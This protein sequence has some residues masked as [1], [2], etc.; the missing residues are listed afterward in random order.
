MCGIIHEDQ[1]VDY[2]ISP[3]RIKSGS[4]TTVVRPQWIDS[5]VYEGLCCLPRDYMIL[6]SCT[7]AASDTRKSGRAPQPFREYLEAYAE[8]QRERLAELIHANW[9]SRAIS[10]EL[11]LSLTTVTKTKR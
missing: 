9:T 11:H 2:I 6:H 1:Y 3:D 7:R 8:R 10:E 5:L 4:T